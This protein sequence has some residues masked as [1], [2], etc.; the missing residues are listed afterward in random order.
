MALTQSA[1]LPGPDPSWDDEVVP[2]LR[3][4]NVMPDHRRL[5]LNELCPGLETE[6]RTLSRRL[7]GMSLITD[8]HYVQTFSS[9]AN[10]PAHD[11]VPQYTRK[12]EDTRPRNLQVSALPSSSRAVP[13]NSLKKPVVRSRTLSQPFSNVAS[14][15]ARLSASEVPNGSARP[16]DPRPTRIPKVSRPTLPTLPSSPPTNHVN[17]FGQLVSHVS[18]SVNGVHSDPLTSREHNIPSLSSLGGLSRQVS[19]ILDEPPPFPTGSVSSMTK[20]QHNQQVDDVPS[21]LSTDSEERPF[22]HWYRGE[23]SRNGGVGELRVVRRQEMLDI[24]T[25][26]HTIA[27]RQIESTMRTTTMA[28]TDDGRWRR[29]RGGSVGEIGRPERDSLYMDEE[30]MDHMGRVLDENPP[31]DLDGE[32]ESD[33]QSTRGGHLASST[34][35]GSSLTSSHQIDVSGASEP[36]L[37]SSQDS[38][39]SS[40]TLTASNNPSTNRRNGSS[41]IPSPP[42]RSTEARPTTPV[43]HVKRG[44]SEQD[45]SVKSTPSAPST[46]RAR[47]LQVKE[48]PTPSAH[49]RAVSPTPSVKKP[50]PNGAKNSRSKVKAKKETSAEDKRRSVA[51]YP[52]SNGEGDMA[53]AIPTWTQPKP[54]EG[55]WD[56]VSDLLLFTDLPN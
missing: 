24:A 7:S 31:T 51:T 14:A 38:S 26:G 11:T 25:Y 33:A 9:L 6:S 17:G 16:S 55:N 47:R 34:R 13:V 18:G 44:A 8:A 20:S 12:S 23:I 15:N 10:A 37:H 48:A 50:K 46:P 28:T 1:R 41:R 45:S 4:R 5:A 40:R 43:Q 30:H 2:A 3:K 39:S 22:E 54:R 32:D 52:L 56:E 29:K 27:K 36:P 42:R 21:R 19:G 35:Q 53:Y 49:R